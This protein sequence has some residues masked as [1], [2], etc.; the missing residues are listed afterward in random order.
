MQS[1]SPHKMKCRNGCFVY[2]LKEFLNIFYSFDIV[3][4]QL[5][6]KCVFFEKQTKQNKQ[7]KKI[8][9]SYI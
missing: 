6:R 4:V 5:W 2:F 7:T 8:C 1:Q 9:L 3:H